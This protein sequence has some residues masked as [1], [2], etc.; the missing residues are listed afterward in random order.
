[1]IRFIERRIREAVNEIVDNKMSIYQTE[2]SLLRGQVAS[3]ATAGRMPSPNLVEL[4][5]YAE[6][7][8]QTEYAVE[9]DPS[10]ASWFKPHKFRL[11]VDGVPHVFMVRVSVRAC[12]QN[13][14]DGTF[15][16]QEAVGDNHTI[17]THVHH[18]DDFADYVD[19]DWDDI[20]HPR[21]YGLV[22]TVKNP[23]NNTAKLRFSLL[24][25]CKEASRDCRRHQG[26]HPR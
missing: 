21:G 8:P 20:G 11:R 18:S 3:A 13:L 4:P 15:R 23:H 14:L 6:V 1:M 2:L 12:S 10:M 7:P 25:E 24:G 22:V 5:A 17:A 9:I 16:N 19:V 26:H